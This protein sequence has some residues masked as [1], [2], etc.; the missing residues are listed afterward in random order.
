MDRAKTSLVINKKGKNI[1]TVTLSLNKVYI[2]I[3][4]FNFF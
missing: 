4:N 2:Y 1:L 3:Y